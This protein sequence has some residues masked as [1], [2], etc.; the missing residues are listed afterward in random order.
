M[1]SPLD[2]DVSSVFEGES[3]GS[4]ET[5]AVLMADITAVVGLTAIIDVHSIA[6][7]LFE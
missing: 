2:V 6:V 3:E 5:T 4:G 1:L 7:L